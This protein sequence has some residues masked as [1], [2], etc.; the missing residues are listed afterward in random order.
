MNAPKNNE[1][2]EKKCT[3]EGKHKRNYERKGGFRLIYINFNFDFLVLYL[4]S[5]LLGQWIYKKVSHALTTSTSVLYQIY[6]FTFSSS[7]Y[8]RYN[9]VTH[10]VNIIYTYSFEVAYCCYIFT[11]YL[12]NIS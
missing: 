5:K 11:K 10:V 2:T 3:H 12:K 9:T 4:F 7:L 8:I 6:T 1:C